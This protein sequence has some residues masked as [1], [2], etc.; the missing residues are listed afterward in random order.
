MAIM[1]GLALTA[2]AALV[3]FQAPLASAQIASAK[4]GGDP[5]L[6]AALDLAAEKDPLP[7]DS[8]QLNS[9]LQKR[10]AE[11]SL[12]GNSR[13]ASVSGRAYPQQACAVLL[14]SGFAEDGRELT[15]TWPVFALYQEG[16]ST[17]P[18]LPKTVAVIDQGDNIGFK[19]IEYLSAPR[20][21]NPTEKNPEGTAF[22]FR[23]IIGRKEN[24]SENYGLDDRYFITKTYIEK[25]G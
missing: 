24:K 18:G 21:M 6:R 16:N 19:K 4:S 5:Q 7:S 25:Y 12:C 22:F 11:K 14:F 15:L 17:I 2:A 20:K 9:W 1:R 10:L 8:S 3:V 13:V 23:A